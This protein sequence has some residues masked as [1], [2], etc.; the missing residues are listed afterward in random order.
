MRFAHL[1]KLCPY[2]RNLVYPWEYG[3]GE[4]ASEGREFQCLRY[5]ECCLEG[6]TLRGLSLSSRDSS[7]RGE[8]HN[9]E[10]EWAEG[11]SK[12]GDEGRGSGHPG[13]G[14]KLCAPPVNPIR[15]VH[16][17]SIALGVAAFLYSGTSRLGGGEGR[18]GIASG[19]GDPRPSL[20]FSP[21]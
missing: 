2:S 18:T 12:R 10:E 16:P 6:H 5:P 14:V 20:V 13:S 21:F 8:G 9:Q 1:S 7:P 4:E 19:A 17:P 3:P 15:L 11:V